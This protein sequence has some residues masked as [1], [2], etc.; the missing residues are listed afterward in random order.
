MHKLNIFDKL[1]SIKAPAFLFVPKINIEVLYGK[2]KNS[3][4]DYDSIV[5]RV[6][7][8][9]GQPVEEIVGKEEVK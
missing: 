5:G 8:I 7:E 9:D 4:G 1:G 2:D 6:I 3:I